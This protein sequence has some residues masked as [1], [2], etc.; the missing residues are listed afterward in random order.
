MLQGSA[1][2]M[3]SEVAHAVASKLK[4]AFMSAARW[5]ITRNKCTVTR[6]LSNTHYVYLKAFYLKYFRFNFQS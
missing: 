5:A 3:L 1:Q 2:P 6:L 4:S